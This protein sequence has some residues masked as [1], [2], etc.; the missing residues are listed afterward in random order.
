MKVLISR[1]VLKP[2]FMVACLLFFLCGGLAL[3]SRSRM[4][5]AIN[6]IFKSGIGGEYQSW[7]EHFLSGFA[8]PSLGLMVAIPFGAMLLHRLRDGSTTNKI[9]LRAHAWILAKSEQE[10]LTLLLGTCAF[11]YIAVSGDWEFNQSLESG[12]FQLGQFAGDTI[13]AIVWFLLL[14]R[15]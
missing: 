5:T 1:R 9:A 3:L 8:S 2:S 11:A 15:L 14:K 4:S 6:S 12:T 13:A 10:L 7:F